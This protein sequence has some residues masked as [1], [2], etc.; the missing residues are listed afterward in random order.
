MRAD[1]RF[2]Q[3]MFYYPASAT[4]DEQLG[5][6]GLCEYNLKSEVLLEGYFLGFDYGCVV[7]IVP[8]ENLVV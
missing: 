8:I 4:I 1:G 5:D 2:P 3:I 6:V 7:V